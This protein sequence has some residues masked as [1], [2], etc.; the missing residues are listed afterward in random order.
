[1]MARAPTC[2]PRAIALKSPGG[3]RNSLSVGNFTHCGGTVYLFTP[4]RQALIDL[5]QSPEV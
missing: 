5:A 1:M 4:G 3:T 2:G